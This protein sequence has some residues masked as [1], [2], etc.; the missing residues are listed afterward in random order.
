MASINK[1]EWGKW[2]VRY[3]T[4]AGATRSKTFDRKLDA[5]DFAASVRVKLR[6]GEFVDP[7][8]GRET[9]AS[10]V[11]DRWLEM[12]M[13]KASTE[14]QVDSF[15]RNHILPTFGPMPLAAVRPAHVQK[16]VRGQS[17][18]LAPT[19]VETQ[20]RILSAVFRSA[21]EDFQI[22]AVSPCKGITLPKKH[23]AEIR[24]L[25]V[26]V[27]D[28]LVQK[29]PA[30]LRSMVVLAAGTGLRL[31]ECLGLT[32]DRVDFL[33]R[34]VRVDRQM[35]TVRGVTEFSSPKTE[36]SVRTVPL[37]RVVI[38]A[39]ALHLERHPV[40]ESGLIFTRDGEPWP[41]NRFNYKWQATR[42]DAGCDGVKFHEL[43]HFYASLLI[44]HGESV[45]AVQKRLGH[46]SASETLDTYSH[47]WP[48]S[49]DSTRA[50]VD[51]V[52][53]AGI[54]SSCVQSVS[55]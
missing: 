35:S 5:E 39:L 14:A 34:T 48:D 27:V 4:D 28:A 18:K 25:S 7:A 10:F 54:V 6:R 37:P 29:A 3:R 53:G 21:V 52:L 45:K 12:Q 32:V 19:T 40:G 36:A 1:T 8:A 2:K 20:Y 9:F 44:A 46:A 43:R 49:D 55:S 50:A 15:L 47:L 23:K 17:A 30:E 16:W 24:P 38:D 31:G 11:A 41:R 42:K 33:R 26:E 51:L 13:H 22:L